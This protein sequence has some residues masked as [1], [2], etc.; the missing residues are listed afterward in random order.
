[1]AN[2][3][4]NLRIWAV[5]FIGFLGV[6]AVAGLGAVEMR[7]SLLSAR[8]AQTRHIVEVARSTVAHFH[9]RSQDGDLTVADAQAAALEALRA[10]R[11]G[12]GEYLWVNDMGPVMLMH[13]TNPALVGKPLGDVAD[14]TGFRLFAAM[15]DTVRKDGAGAIAYQWPKPGSDQPVAKISFVQG[16]AP[17]GWVI[18]SG[19]Y[20]DDVDA[21]FRDSLSALAAIGGALVLVTIGVS[22]LIQRSIVGPL[23]GLTGTM[24]RLA[25]GE[26]SIDI[27]GAGTRSEIGAM[28]DAVR[29]FR[30][31]AIRVR[32]M[33]TAA[34]L[35]EEKAAAEKKR[36]LD[37]VAAENARIEAEIAA[38]VDAAGRGEFDQRMALDGK[39]GFHRSLAEGM[40]RVV[41]LVDGAVAELGG[42]LS[43]LADGD[44]DRRMVG[45]YQG[46]LERLKVDY[47]SAVSTLSDTVRAVAAT[48]EVV[49]TATGEI[50]AGTED[51]A[52]R[53]EQQASNL[54]ETAAA[55]EELT[56]TVRQNADNARQANQLSAAARTAA[57]RGGETV[58][59][60]I[61]AMSEIE[62]SSHRISDIVS[63]IQEIAFQ[64]N[65]LA[66]NASVE[67]ARAGEVGKGFAVVASEVRALAQRSSEA[68]KD[69]KGLIEESGRQVGQGVELVNAAGGTLTDIV[70]SVKKV[71]DIVA[72][73]SSASQEQSTGLE[74]INTAVT[75]MD[76]MTQQNA[77]LV[78]ETTAA[79]QSLRDQAGELTH[80]L[81]A[82]QASATAS[83][84]TTMAAPARTA[85]SSSATAAPAAGADDDWDA[86]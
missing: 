23:R 51:L 63:L 66:L 65:L 44:L 53:T 70:T 69:I 18:G 1:M 48:A 73:I 45:A 80:R 17:W 81:Q 3:S 56:A 5:V 84:S 30:D 79:A 16:F 42:C 12:D 38:V 40:N 77:A 34:R 20:L 11:Y 49:R 61:A 24:G 27:P 28:A 26:T 82:F 33:E 83:A 68:S 71:A 21:A 72:E 15:V 52:D 85:P 50:A 57:E 47:N 62:E 2:V 8:E 41:G 19:I 76:E 25:K 58:S 29:V 10:M 9:A 59:K 35:N 74:Q 22:L 55:M 78:E 39:Q 31:N 37:Q 46:D 13:P 36:L 54:Q 14:P 6:V 60:A 86:F 75:N 4:I 7:A 32:E 43:A 64:T 67:A